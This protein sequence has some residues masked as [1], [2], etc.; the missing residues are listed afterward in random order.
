MSGVHDAP[1]PALRVSVFWQDEQ[2]RSWLR[3]LSLPAG[4]TAGDAVLASGLQPMLGSARWQGP[5]PELRLAVF[6]RLCDPAGMLR[7]GDRVDITRALRVD[8]KQA[9]R[10]R[11][12]AA[13]RSR[14]AARASG[15]GR[16]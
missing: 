9:R 15:R 12:Q 10:L 13:A 14:P 8:P 2:G 16:A 5:E 7:D 11:A 1:A 3:E 4:A 6:G